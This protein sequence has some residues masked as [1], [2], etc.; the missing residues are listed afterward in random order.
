MKVN[1]IYTDL[2]DGLI[3]LRVLDRIEPGCVDWKKVTTKLS[4]K[5]KDI[6]D[7]I[8]NCNECIN[9]GKKKLGFSLLNCKEEALRTKDKMLTVAYLW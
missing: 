3:L 7:I 9:V 4:G 8:N 2:C 1:N 6:Y 5:K